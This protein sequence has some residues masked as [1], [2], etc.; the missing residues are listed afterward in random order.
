MSS[1]RGLG[2]YLILSKTTIC[3]REELALIENR[4]LEKEM[5]AKRRAERLAKNIAVSPTLSLRLSSLFNDDIVVHSQSCRSMVTQRG[6]KHFGM[7]TLMTRRKTS[8]NQTLNYH[9]VTILELNCDVRLNSKLFW[10]GN[11]LPR[12]YGEFPLEMASTPIVDIDPYYADKRTFIVINKG[13]AISRYIV[14]SYMINDMTMCSNTMDF[15]VAHHKFHCQVLGNQGNVDPLS[16][17]PNPTDRPN[18]L[19][20]PHVRLRHHHNHPCQL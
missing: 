6:P 2:V 13:G 15:L 1:F 19:H 12:R 11:D 4:I 20:P 16:V 7:L 18:R 3:F 14:D 9:R 5:A 17:S 8:W 10:T